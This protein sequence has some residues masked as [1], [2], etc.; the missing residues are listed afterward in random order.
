MYSVELPYCGDSSWAAI[1]LQKY[2][3]NTLKII[4]IT[5]IL[6]ISQKERKTE[7]S[8][9]FFSPLFYF[10]STFTSLSNVWRSEIEKK[11]VLLC[12]L[13]LF[14]YLVHC[15]K[16]FLTL[17]MLGKKFSRWHFEIF[18]YCFLENRIWHFMQIV[19]L[20]DNLH[21]VPDPIF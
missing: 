18:F 15:K 16:S 3:K 2:E 6:H 20:G 10:V 17:C 1:L 9:L 5:V 7:E 12:Y 13:K 14:F 4:K 11:I 19:S 8:I 21:E